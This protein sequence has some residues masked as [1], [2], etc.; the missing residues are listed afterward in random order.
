MAEQEFEFSTLNSKVLFPLTTVLQTLHKIWPFTNQVFTGR[1]VEIDLMKTS[2]KEEHL[3]LMLREH[4]GRGADK[5]VR[6]RD[7]RVFYET[8]S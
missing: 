3:C 5:S 2:T 8:V 4:G 6:T 7:Q 1:A